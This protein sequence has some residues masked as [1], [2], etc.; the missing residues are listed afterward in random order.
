MRC[1][2]GAARVAQRLSYDLQQDFAG[3][4]GFCHIFMGLLGLAQG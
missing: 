3:M 1:F 2:S 4:A